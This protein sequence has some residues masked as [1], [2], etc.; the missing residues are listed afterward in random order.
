MFAIPHISHPSANEAFVVISRSS[1]LCT[2]RPEVEVK[3]ENTAEEPLI[4]YVGDSGEGAAGEAAAGD[5]APADAKV[6]VKEEQ[7]LRGCCTLAGP[8]EGPVLSFGCC[9]IAL[10]FTFQSADVRGAASILS[11]SDSLE[12]Q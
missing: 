10:C 1:R 6:E 12:V 7:V 8:R 2:S 3:T 11:D 4:Q 9:I 5:A